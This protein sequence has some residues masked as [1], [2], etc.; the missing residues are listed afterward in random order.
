[1]TES[2]L[3]DIEPLRRRCKSLALLDAIFC[4]KKAHRYYSFDPAF[5]PGEQLASMKNGQGDDWHIL[6]S[7]A[8]AVIKGVDRQAA[9]Y[10][11][12]A[13]ARETLA[14][15][16]PAFAAFLASSGFGGY[17]GAYAFWRKTA[18]PAWTKL[19]LAPADL[20]STDDGAGW[21]L[22]LLVE[23]P[24][25]FRDYAADYYLASTPLPAI[26]H[27]YAGA[28][29]TEDIIRA[30]NP[31]TTLAQAQACAAEIGYP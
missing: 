21:M 30:L 11:S 17:G 27:I 9:M 23:G 1:M 4:P 3:P 26:E 2:E 7:R 20:K 28:P 18:D 6:F 16:P 29:L 24:D 8:G 25:A 12:K 14:Q 19:A 5:G 15:S 10:G 22:G 31:K 13:F